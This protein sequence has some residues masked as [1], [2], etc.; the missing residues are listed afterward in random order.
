MSA[1]DYDILI[2]GGG[3]VGAS[4]A[5]ALSQVK[6]SSLRIAVV[7]STPFNSSQQPSFDART[8]AISDSSKV[9]FQTLGLW[10]EILALG[11]MPIKRI[12]VSD[13]GHIGSTHMDARE[14]GVAALGYVVETRVIGEVLNH[15]IDKNE[16]IALI[17]PATVE[18]FDVAADV[19][20]VSIN[21]DGQS[22]TV[23][24][25][26]VVA[27]DGGE[28]RLRQL[29][30]I[31]T[32]NMNYG[33]SAVIAN[34]ACDRAHQNIAYERFTDS[35]P[36]ALL[37]SCDPDCSDPGCSDP[38]CSDKS[39]AL[40]WTEKPKQAEAIA[41]LDDDAFL[42]RL[43]QQFGRRAGSFIKT[44]SRTLYPLKF[45]QARDSVRPRLAIIGNAAH[46]LHPVSGQGFNLGLRDAAVLAQLI[47][48]ATRSGEDP[49]VLENLQNY[50]RWRRRDQ[51]QTALSTDSLVRIFSNN[52]PPLAL[53]RNLGL[54][55]LDIL[56][57]LKK[58]LARHAMGYIGKQP[59]LSRGLPL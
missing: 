43:Q 40:V 14:Q 28:S 12:H 54:L 9:I 16:N 22:E 25:K 58:R 45:Q 55:A 50:A 29:A 18:G 56:P 38:G 27:A 13:R 24:A 46:S 15:Y 41:A 5:V 53:A 49:G 30:G 20:T 39:Y 10:D 17:C 8:V 44:S 59:R 35:G 4:L 51:W 57:P 6:D 21:R 33:Q 31:K 36:M 19:A 3:M 37:P 52:F 7:E 11:A 32:L 2:V 23:Q 26:L 48:D 47:V 34:V 42:H 1:A